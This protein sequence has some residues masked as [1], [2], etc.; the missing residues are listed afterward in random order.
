MATLSFSN[1][2]HVMVRPCANA[3]FVYSRY[4][5]KPSSED[6]PT[7]PGIGFQLMAWSLL[8]ARG[9]RYHVD[10]ARSPQFNLQFLRT[11]RNSES[12]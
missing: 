10:V 8:L 5:G 4:D 9:Y 1:D 12:L 3:S 11:K 6:P 7:K 2:S